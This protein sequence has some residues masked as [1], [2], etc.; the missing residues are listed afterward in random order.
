MKPLETTILW[1]KP[2]SALVGL[3]QVMTDM[4]EA[5][6]LESI[7]EMTNLGICCS[8]SSEP[9]VGDTNSWDL[10]SLAAVLKNSFAEDSNLLD[11]VTWLSIWIWAWED[12]A[13]VQEDNSYSFDHSLVNSKSESATDSDMDVVFVMDTCWIL[14]QVTGLS[15]SVSLVV[16]R[17]HNDLLA[18]VGK[19][20]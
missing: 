1:I 4:E 18:K 14:G 11:D 17:D 20:N 12:I 13:I 7:T 16:W 8:E 6:A 3:L 9:I 5:C 2:D 19:T 10:L 15:L